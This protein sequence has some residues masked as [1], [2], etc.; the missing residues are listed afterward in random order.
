MSSEDTKI[1]RQGGT[2]VRQARHLEH[3][4]TNLRVSTSLNFAPEE[5]YLLHPGLS[6]RYKT[7]LLPSRTF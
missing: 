5:F 2:G 1:K 6:P 7:P 4:C 3:T